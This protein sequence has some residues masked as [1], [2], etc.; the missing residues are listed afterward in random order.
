ML[1]NP[2]PFNNA[3]GNRPPLWP[4]CLDKGSPQAR[5]LAAAWPLFA[6]P[7]VG[8]HDVS[9]QGAGLTLGAAAET[10]TWLKTAAFSGY[11]LDFDGGDEAHVAGG[12]VPSLDIT[13][14]QITLSAWIKPDTTGSFEGA[15]II[16]KRTNGGGSDVYAI[17]L[18]SAGGIKGFV[19]RLNTGTEKS[20]GTT[21]LVTPGV[22]QHWVA[23][24]DGATM[25]IYRNGVSVTSTA[26]TGNIENSARAVYLG[27][28]EAET[29]YYDGSMA[30]VRVYS[31][32]LS[33]GEVRALYDP[34]TRWGLY[35]E[36][37]SSVWTAIL[38]AANSILVTAGAVVSPGKTVVGASKTIYVTLTGALDLTGQ[39]V[40]GAAKTLE[41]VTK[42]DLNTTGQAVVGAAKTILNTTAGALQIAGQNVVGSAGNTIS[43]LKGSLQTAGQT[44]VGAS[45][46]IY[47]TTA[48]ALGVAGQLVTTAGANIVSVA[49][50]AV[51]VIRKTV[52]VAGDVNSLVTTMTRA[53]VRVLSRGL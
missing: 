47:V 26:K 34:Q 36:R 43:V 12:D 3:V 20:L 40:V 2:A 45:K 46:T 16:S 1:L 19:F 44:V 10:P 13:G 7:G 21:T 11:A 31:R 22:W 51:G 30:D 27:H 33:A 49:K 23:T 14:D 38:D 18:A 25:R 39:D 4:F 28:R 17:Y 53:L 37:S 42:G 50:G 48:G 35:K 29:R 41:V 8:L 52:T 32:C 6:G 24:Y 9:G 15:R 5:G